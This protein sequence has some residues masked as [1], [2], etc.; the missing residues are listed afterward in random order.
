MAAKISNFSILDL[1]CCN[2]AGFSEVHTATLVDNANV[3]V[4]DHQMCEI[5]QTK[6]LKNPLSISRTKPGTEAQL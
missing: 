5:L 2:T 3:G 6:F 4:K 1:L